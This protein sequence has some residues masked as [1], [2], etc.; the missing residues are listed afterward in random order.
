MH[1]THCLSPLM[2]RP[3]RLCRT[4]TGEGERI[5]C[6]PCGLAGSEAD[7][8]SRSEVGTGE[9]RKTAA[10]LGGQLWRRAQAGGAQHDPQQTVNSITLRECGPECSFHGAVKPFK[11]SVVLQAVRHGMTEFHP[12]TLSNR[13]PQL[14]S[15]LSTPVGYQVGRHARRR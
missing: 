15:E 7:S 5:E 8:S 3:K 9:C 2:T 11:Q 4:T 10:E 13:H 6:C 14:Q 1:V 12:Q